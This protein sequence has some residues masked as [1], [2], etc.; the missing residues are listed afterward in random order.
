MALHSTLSSPSPT[1]QPP[2]LFSST[3]PLKSQALLLNLN[4]FTNSA[5]RSL[6]LSPPAVPLR[7]PRQSLLLKT[8]APLEPIQGRKNRCSKSKT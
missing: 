7:S 3:H 4:S 8:K 6:R 2:P 5:T 1:L